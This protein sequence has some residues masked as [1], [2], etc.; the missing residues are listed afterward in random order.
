[1]YPGALRLDMHT[2]MCYDE[3]NT[4]ESMGK[5][6]PSDVYVRK[7][8]KVKEAN[9]HKRKED[10]LSEGAHGGHTVHLPEHIA[11]YRESA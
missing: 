8:V 1:M 10:G 5:S 11:Y 9:R 7:A 6:I 3:A 4:K 2:W